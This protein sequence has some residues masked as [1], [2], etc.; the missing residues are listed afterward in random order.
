[1][2]SITA[3][4]TCSQNLAAGQC[5][6]PPGAL[7]FSDKVH[8]ERT[9]KPAL[10]CFHAYLRHHMDDVSDARDDGSARTN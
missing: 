4:E 5:N 3:H 2:E 7:D 8:L 1:M 6:N 9:L 10:Q